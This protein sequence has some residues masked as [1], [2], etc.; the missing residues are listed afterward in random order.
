[1]LETI[2]GSLMFT[3]ATYWFW[4]NFVS[5]HRKRRDR[6]DKLESAFFRSRVSRTSS[7]AS[8]GQTIPVP[9]SPCCA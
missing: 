8:L 7:G 4:I 2:S 9:C 6:F 5:Q 1:M 3:A